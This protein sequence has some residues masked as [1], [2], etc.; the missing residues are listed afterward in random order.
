MVCLALFVRICKFY[1]LFEMKKCLLLLFFFLN[2]TFFCSF[3]RRAITPLRVR[4]TLHMVTCSVFIFNRFLFS[5]LIL[6]GLLNDDI[7]ALK[8]IYSWN[9]FY[10]R[11]YQVF[12]KRANL[13]AKMSKDNNSP[14]NCC[15]NL[16]K[17]TFVSLPIPNPVQKFLY[18]LIRKH[19]PGGRKIISN[20]VRSPATIQRMKSNPFC[21]FHCFKSRP[22]ICLLLSLFL[23][24][25]VRLSSFCIVIAII[26]CEYSK[27]RTCSDGKAKKNPKTTWNV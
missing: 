20:C 13:C 18:L 9:Q 4:Y 25:Y 16:D 22:F 3:L 21:M 6:F 10:Y 7:V 8:M 23:S 26:E 12:D 19:E 15:H 2:C 24:V 11:F 5:S 17:W 27:Q 14:M 1:V